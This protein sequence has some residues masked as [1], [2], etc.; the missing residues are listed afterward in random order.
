MT[1]LGF[2]PAA[3]QLYSRLLPLT[4]WPCMVVAETLSTS[5]GELKEEAAPLIESGVISCGETLTVLSPPA[6]VAHMLERDAFSADFRED[7]PRVRQI[8]GFTHETQRD[9]VDAKLGAELQVVDVFQR[10]RCGRQ[11]NSRGIDP[12]VLAQ[13]PSLLDPRHNFA[14]V[15][16][17]DRELDL[18]GRLGLTADRLHRS[19]ADAAEPVRL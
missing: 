17:L 18:A 15:R 16:C 14:A 3:A 10:E 9:H 13:Q 12:L 1:A 5:E 6:V 2:D 4:G 11:R 8:V 19:V 7:L